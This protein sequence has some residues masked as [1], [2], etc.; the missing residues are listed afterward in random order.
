MVEG[1]RNRVPYLEV[2]DREGGVATIIMPPMH[3]R[4]G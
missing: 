4:L 1:Y 3:R 2:P